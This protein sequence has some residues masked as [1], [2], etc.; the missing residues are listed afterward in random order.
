[1][2]L[3]PLAMA[4]GFVLSAFG[5]S[6]AGPWAIPPEGCGAVASAEDAG[7]GSLRAGQVLRSGDRER[8]RDLVPEAFL[9]AGELF[10]HEDME[11]EI[12]PCHRDYAPPAFFRE[13][14]RRYRG[15][16]VLRDDGNR[17]ET[18]NTVSVPPSDS[19]VKKMLSVGRLDRGR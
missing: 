13:A 18:W 5:A 1:M 11:L 9:D 2:P 12:G 14:T 4:L 8:L 3:L 15:R 6:A 17:W 19:E 7:A 16:A 10:F